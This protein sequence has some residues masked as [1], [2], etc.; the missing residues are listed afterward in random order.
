MPSSA[1]RKLRSLRT[2]LQASFPLHPFS[3]IPPCVEGMNRGFHA[4]RRSLRRLTRRFRGLRVPFPG[5]AR[6]LHVLS[7]LF[8]GIGGSFRVFPR[9]FGDANPRTSTFTAALLRVAVGPGRVVSWLLV[10]KR[11]LSRSAAEFLNRAG[12][13]VRR[14]KRLATSAGWLLRNVSES[15]G[16]DKVARAMRRG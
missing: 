8:R 11:R 15:G 2:A 4:L 16:P 14:A 7:S 6:S 1:P 13:P 10:G 3:E 5:L 9:S 12:S